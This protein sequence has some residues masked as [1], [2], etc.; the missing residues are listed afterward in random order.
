MICVWR[1]AK[2]TP[3]YSAND[4]SGGGAKSVGGRWNSKGRAVVYAASTI[5]LATLETLAHIGTEI[6][7]RN[8]F[9]VKMEVPDH[10]W[11][12]R[13]TLDTKTLDVTW[14]SEPAGAASI[15]AGD[16]WLDLSSSALL[17]V[18]SVLIP[19]E[20]N[21]LIN[22]AHPDATAISATVVRQYIY[23]PRFSP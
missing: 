3:T 13:S 12:A 19:E 11:D 20:F 7:A 8:R 15:S 22:P 18:P 21:V 1:I 17:L 5:S 16:Q 23:D 10:I 4:M 9:L 2:N 6:A 14:V